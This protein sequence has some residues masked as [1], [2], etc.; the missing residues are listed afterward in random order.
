MQRKLA[1][2][3]K[4]LLDWSQ[5]PALEQEVFS[6]GFEYDAMFNE[7]DFFGT[8]NRSRINPEINREID[9]K[10]DQT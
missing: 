1:I 10:R 2:D 8:K 6:Q 9:P 3:Y 7:T 4:S 5:N